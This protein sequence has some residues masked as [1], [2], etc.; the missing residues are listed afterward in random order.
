MMNFTDFS[1]CKGYLEIYKSY[2]DGE[3][4][5]VYAD[6]NVICSGM[7]VTLAEL[8]NASAGSNIDDYRIDL[9]QVGI[10]GNAER[11]VSGTGN[12]G[13]ALGTSGYVGG[14]L[15]VRLQSLMAS[16]LIFTDRAFGEISQAFIKKTAP[17]RVQFHVVL[18]EN[19]GNDATGIN[20]IG[21]FSR[22]PVRTSTPAAV[23]C[24]YR[25]F[26]TLTKSDSFA[27]VF[28]WTIE[29]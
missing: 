10:G 29:F 6:N 11:Q 9:F 3:T 24:A 17:R 19:V 21:L 27:L 12:L 26:P 22:N 25:F 28:K 1:E 5:L 7:G 20:E 13:D 2:R 8:F 15:D 23:L 14:S 18:D 16:G 4:T